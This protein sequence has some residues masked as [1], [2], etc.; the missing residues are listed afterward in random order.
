MLLLLLLLQLLEARELLYGVEQMNVLQA[1]GLLV[2]KHS[3]DSNKSIARA[4]KRAN[5]DTSDSV[6][7]CK[8]AQEEEAR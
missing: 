1:D 3:V 6:M 4:H 5:I 2:K 7:L 8:Q